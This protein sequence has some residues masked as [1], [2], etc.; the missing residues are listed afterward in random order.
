[1][2]RARVAQLA[3]PLAIVYAAILGVI[4]HA[5]EAPAGLAAMALLAPVFRAALLPE[6]GNR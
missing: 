1:V 6:R 3:I 4:P 2:N 5:L